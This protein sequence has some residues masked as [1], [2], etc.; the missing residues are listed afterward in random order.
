MENL[1]EINTNI[2][3]N[4]TYYRKSA[5]LTQAELAE[6]INYSDKSISKWES[7][8]G[9]PDIYIL[10]QLAKLYGVTVNDLV[11]GDAE[12][13]TVD[14]KKKT[15]GAR[16]LIMLLS[17][18]IVW[19]VATCL[20][21]I[22]EL[23]VAS[24]WSGLIFLYA[25]VANAIVLLVYACIWKYR[26]LIFICVS[27]IIWMSITS[28]YCTVNTVLVVTGG[29]LKSLWCLF[30][31]G[32]PLQILEIFWMFFRYTLQT[33]VTKIKNIASKKKKLN[34]QQKGK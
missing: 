22:L 25:T 16:L 6:K 13:K 27:T 4:L 11:Y 7:G 18:G 1:H 33:T 19:L 17:T 12:K 31:V 5:G 29:S 24:D 34:H 14:V 2:V 10:I 23:T 30:L 32:I 9:V 21:V 28:I 8:N 3:K 26:L 20:F 15:F